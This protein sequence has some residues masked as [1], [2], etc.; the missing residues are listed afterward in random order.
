MVYFNAH[1]T[2]HSI[3]CIDITQKIYTPGLEILMKNFVRGELA[4]VKATSIL[5]C[6][7]CFMQLK[8]PNKIV[9]CLKGHKICEPCSEK[10]AVVSCLEK[11]GSEVYCRP[12]V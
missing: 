12:K 6:P 8:P 4:K 2:L 7:V 1:C 9:Q 10:E 11:Y 3:N 5:E